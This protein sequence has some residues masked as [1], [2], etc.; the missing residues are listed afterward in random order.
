MTNIQ[1]YAFPNQK[2]V[3]IGYGLSDKPML[4]EGRRTFDVCY[5]LE[6]VFNKDCYKNGKKFKKHVRNYVDAFV[7]NGLSIREI[8][9]EEDAKKVLALY[10]EWNKA[11]LEADALNPNHFAEHSQRY[12]DCLDCV[13]ERK[14]E[15]G[16]IAGMFDVNNNLL[17]YQMYTTDEK[18]EWIFGMT[19]ATTKL[20]KFDHLANIA[21]ISFLNYF[22]QNGYK[23]ANWGE[24]GGDLKLLEYKEAFPNFRI[25]YGR[26]DIE[27]KTGTEKDI[28][29]IVDFMNAHSTPEIPFPT[30]Y[31]P[32]SIKAGNVIMAFV[33]DRLAGI[34]ECRWHNEKWLM[35]NLIVAE[36]YRCQGVAARLL[37]QLPKPFY[38]NC[39]K[40]NEKAN[41]FYQNLSDVVKVGESTNDVGESW[42]YRYGCDMKSVEKKYEG[43]E[44]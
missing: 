37:N 43:D 5:E 15:R 26:L 30:E 21:T 16:A 42:D 31:M 12:R 24:C 34:V 38:F 44:E 8:E 27:Y 10:D 35:T 2:D 36:E 20:S 33:N 9:T 17:S 11:K 6:K 19:T 32:D 29:T 4:N 28:E 39:Y 14:L 25:Y 22:Y 7:E 3:Q 40:I 13:F 1:E 41:K 18:K 23:Y